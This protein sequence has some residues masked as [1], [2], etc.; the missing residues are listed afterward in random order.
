MTKRKKKKARKKVVYPV[1]DQMNLITLNEK[2]QA[3]ALADYERYVQKHFRYFHY[4]DK[5]KLRYKPCYYQFP[6]G[7][8]TRKYLDNIFQRARRYHVTPEMITQSLEQMR[9]MYGDEAVDRG[10]Y[11]AE[12]GT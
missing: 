6:V 2:E 9:E 5:E 10:L 3:A 12:N 7:E 8:L 1:I 4:K 11:G